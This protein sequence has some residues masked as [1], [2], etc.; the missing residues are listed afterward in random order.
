MHL[1]MR[2]VRRGSNDKDPTIS[3]SPIRHHFRAIFWF[4][5]ATEERRWSN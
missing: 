3:D 1:I 5:V 4:T 2:R